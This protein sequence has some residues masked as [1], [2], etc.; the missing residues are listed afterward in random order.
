MITF[1][2]DGVLVRFDDTGV[3]RDRPG[4]I[5][6][7]LLK[8][9]FYEERFLR[10]IHSLG[11]SGTYVDIGAF[12]GTHTVFFGRICNADQVH[13]FEPRPPVYA[14]LESNVA[15]NGL[16]DVVVAHKMALTD[17]DCE[18]TLDFGDGVYVVPG[19]RLDDVVREKVV[20][21]KI[22]VEGMEPSVLRGARRL[23]RR[24]RPVVFAEATTDEHHEALVAAMH[25]LRYEPTGRVF[26]ASPTYEFAHRADRRFHSV[27][28]QRL[29]RWN[30]LAASPVGRAAKQLMPASVRRVRRA[31]K[32]RIAAAAEPRG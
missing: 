16:T 14:R 22:D 30:R 18:V 5:H 3:D 25:K 27:E 29:R 4:L 12:V 13:S 1:E 28:V 9:H 23:L 7:A 31:V 24:S 21:I 17:R 19:R 6:G 15:L 2:H 11:L 8:N 10:Y 26:N 20:V 32:R